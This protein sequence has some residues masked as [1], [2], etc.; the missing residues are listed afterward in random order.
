MSNAFLTNA[1]QLANLFNNAGILL[2]SLLGHGQRTIEGLVAS[3]ETGRVNE[4]A[5]LDARD[6]IELLVAETSPSLGQGLAALEG[7]ASLRHALHSPLGVGCGLLGVQDINNPLDALALLLLQGVKMILPRGRLTLQNQDS[8]FRIV[9]LARLVGGL[10]DVSS[11]EPSLGV[12]VE[13]AV[14]LLADTVAG[15]LEPGIFLRLG[16]HGVLGNGVVPVAVEAANHSTEGEATV[17]EALLDAGSLES[18][19]IVDA[20]AVVVGVKGLDEA[21]V[22]LV[23]DQANLVTVLRRRVGHPA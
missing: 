2:Q 19:G 18:I 11:R 3:N 10:D 14:E 13:S 22:Q 12:V 5:T 20:D 21:V 8:A 7:V 15:L 17:G 23:P 1:D 6:L 9:L 4:N 16:G